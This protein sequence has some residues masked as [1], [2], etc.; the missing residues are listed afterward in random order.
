MASNSFGDVFRITTWGESHG[1][2]IGVV[3]DGCPAGVSL[4]EEEV[5]EAL[6]K[7]R[8]GAGGAISSRNESDEAQILSG[9]FEGVTTGAPI[10]IL[11]PNRDVDSS[12]YDEVKDLY[13][14]GHANYT[15]LKKY[16]V[17][18]HR[19]G[20]RAS[21]R[22]TASRVAAGAIADKILQKEGITVTAKVIEMG[23]A[24][25]DE[26]DGVVKKA[27][28]EGDSVG[29]IV[30]VI[31]QG[32]P[33]GL[34]DPIYDKMEAKLAS[35]MLSLPAVKGFEIGAGFEAA[36]MRGSEHNDPILPEDRFGSNHAGGTL[37]GIT[38]GQ[39]LVFRVAFKPTPTIALSQETTDIKGEAQTIA[40][41]T[42][43]SDACVAIRGAVAAAAMTKLV[44]ADSLLKGL[45]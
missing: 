31:A 12:Y 14:P 9:V 42:V 15:Y 18:D 22:E 30:E 35:A 39:P 37:G 3:V 6:V 1:K 5:N 41:P 25:G 23:G 32:V 7:R 8:P 10:S 20:G 29:G 11:I 38:T 34:G 13:R 26:M 4:T 28:E 24:T 40:M 36:R 21:A 43:R 44:L 17:F 27:L 2:A 33:V 16:G 19:G 45:L